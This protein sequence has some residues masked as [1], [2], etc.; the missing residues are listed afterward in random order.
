MFDAIENNLR[1]GME[2][3]RSLNDEQYCDTSVEPYHSSIGGHI[4]HV[5]DI[6]DCIFSGL[7]AGHV[8][9]AARN[10]NVSVETDRQIALEY[11]EE[12]L[13]QLQA[14]RSVDLNQL[15][16]V[17]DDLGCGEVTCNY[18]LAAALVQAHSH[19][20]HHFASLG[21]IISSLGLELPNADFGY[22]PTTPEESRVN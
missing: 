18:T 21:Y 19:A 6:F 9:L 3:V 1:V 12:V 20:I 17:C 11:F 15:V 4:R 13:R 22:N 14:L 5:L 8:N 7:D 10:R 16:E 2:W